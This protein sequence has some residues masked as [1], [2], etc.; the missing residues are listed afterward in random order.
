MRQRLPGQTGSW[1]RSPQFECCT[2]H[3]IWRSLSLRTDGSKYPSVRECSERMRHELGPKLGGRRKYKGQ[4]QITGYKGC[5]SG[6]GR[7]NSHWI[8]SYGGD[9]TWVSQASSNPS[10]HEFPRVFQCCSPGPLLFLECIQFTVPQCRAVITERRKS[11]MTTRP[12]AN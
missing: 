6:H 9:G 1:G 11:R 5:G 4:E 7:R 8:P 10:V 12:V 2:I 3:S